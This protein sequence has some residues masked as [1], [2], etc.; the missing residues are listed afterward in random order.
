[1][2]RVR[3]TA[4]MLAILTVLITILF[5]VV[6]DMDMIAIAS[7]ALAAV[8]LFVVVPFEAADP[9]ARKRVLA[10]CIAYVAAIG[11]ALALAWQ[12]GSGRAPMAAL[13]LLAM[14]GFALAAWS[15]GIRNRHSRSKWSH[16]YDR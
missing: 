7:S 16:Y 10:A 2:R 9:P 12:T 1:M 13:A 14:G 6:P 5:C 4:A 15:F 3:L 11:V 8:C